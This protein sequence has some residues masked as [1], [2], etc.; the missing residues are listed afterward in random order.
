MC[1]RDSIDTGRRERGVSRAHAAQDKRPRSLA[2]RTVIPV[3]GNRYVVYRVGMAVGHGNS[4]AQPDRSPGTLTSEFIGDVPA[5]FH[6]VEPVLY[7]RILLEPGRE[8]VSYTHLSGR[9]CARNGRSGRKTESRFS[10]CSACAARR[11]G[12]A[13]RFRFWTYRRKCATGNPRSENK[14]AG[15]STAS[16]RCV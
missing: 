4:S 2:F 11:G 12:S 14:P 7:V 15:R 8:P 1:I 5:H 3:I 9:R 6:A 16:G 10:Y 13:I